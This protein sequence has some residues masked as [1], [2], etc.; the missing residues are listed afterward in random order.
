MQLLKKENKT[1]IEYRAHKRRHLQKVFVGD[2]FDELASNFEALFMDELSERTISTEM[3]R[4]DGRETTDEIKRERHVDIEFG[5]R[6]GA[7][8][9]KRKEGGTGEEKMFSI[10][11]DMAVRTERGG[12]FFVQKEASETKSLVQ[13][14]PSSDTDNGTRVSVEVGGHFPARLE[15]QS[16]RRELGSG[17]E[18]S[19]G[20]AA[21]DGLE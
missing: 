9:A 21:G 14:D 13:S 19:V 6:E 2:V 1:G 4:N 10:A 5:E 16:S 12:T 11:M 20:D 17:L 15:S 18:R 3:R 8:L 7:S